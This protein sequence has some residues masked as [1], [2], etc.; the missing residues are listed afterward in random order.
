MRVTLASASPRRRELLP[1]LLDQFDVLP[2]DIDEPL[3]NDAI[4][5]ARMLARDKA[6]HIA[7]RHSG[8]IVIGA[9]TIVFDDRRLY[10]KPTDREDAVAMLRGLRGR[11][12]R[13]VTGIAVVS[14]GRTSDDVAISTVT[15]GD[16]SDA[17]IDRFVASG[18]PLDKAGAYAIQHEEFAV[19]ERLDGCYCNVVGLPLW[20]LKALLEDAGITCADPSATYA[21]CSDCPDR[22]ASP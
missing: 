17:D 6:R 20:R 16:L 9:D 8:A 5:D 7:A 18:V 10:G 14:E 12:H 3:G 19:V 1:A 22:L 2:A 15:L 11:E 4:A 13:V 21:R